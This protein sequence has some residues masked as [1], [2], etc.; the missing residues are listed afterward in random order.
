MALIEI[1]FLKK[2][3]YNDIDIIETTSCGCH[4]SEACIFSNR[5]CMKKK[6]ILSEFISISKYLDQEK[7]LL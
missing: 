1:M 6:G 4:Y 7:I 3:R 5:N 2:Y